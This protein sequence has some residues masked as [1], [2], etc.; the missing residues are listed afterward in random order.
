MAAIDP[1][2]RMHS[3]KPAPGT[4]QNEILHSLVSIASSAANTQIDQFGLRLADALMQFSD[5]S[6]DSKQA[7]LSFNAANLLKKNVYAFHF[8][9]ST[10]LQKT[11]LH[12]IDVNEFPQRSARAKTDEV[13]SLVPY[14]DMEKKLLLSNMARPLDA[15][16]ADQLTALRIRIAHLLGREEFSNNQNPFRPEVLLSA[17]TDAWCEFNPDIET[18]SLVLPLL[19]PDVFL[20]LT[21]VL[22]ALNN[23]LIACGIMPELADFYNIKKTTGNLSS[24]KTSDRLDPATLQQLRQIFSP[25]HEIAAIPAIPAGGIPMIAGAPMIPGL[26]SMPQSADTVSSAYQNQALQAAVSSNPLLGFLAGLQKNQL[27]HQAAAGQ[28]SVAPGVSMLASIKTEAPLGTLTRIDESTIDLLTKIFDVVFRDQNIPTEIK[29]L[30]GFLQVPVL[31]AALIDKDFFFKEEHPARRLIELL[32]KTSVGWDQSRGQDDPLYQTIKRN[33]SRVQQEFDEQATVFSDVVCDLESFIQQEESTS[34]EALSEP[35]A[36][37]LIQE[38]LGQANKAAKHEVALRIGTGEVVAFVETF[39][40]N[41]WVSVLALAYSIKD[42]KPRAVESALKT[43]DD[44]V[45]SVKPKIKKEERKELIAKLP[46]MLSMLNKWLNLVKLDDADR[47]QFFAELAECHASIVRAPL[48]MSPLRRL[49]IAMDVAKQAAERRLQRRAVEEAD[50][51]AD[52][53]TC[54]V[55]KLERGM[56]L[57]FI[58]ENA[59]ARKVKLSWVSPLRS[60]YIFSS[61]DKT[62][63]FSLSAEDL[64]QALREGRAQVILLDGLVDRAIT[65]ALGNGGANDAN[66]H[67]KSAA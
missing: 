15:T 1:P 60:L 61:R 18:H 20:D 36:E 63:S 6:G 51:V 2:D 32:T 50:Q 5:T 25:Q 14:A 47:L 3:A 38:K 22:L 24:G 12:E 7:S 45:W 19:R 65:E 48:E 46:S 59:A 54:H 42:E 4:A 27:V 66:M 29:G 37:A 31:K 35:I 34:A 52:D 67:E 10:H 17:I 56:W 8:V 30:I 39:L 11:I 57:E 13:L 58:Q 44:L 49:E 62:E 26:G 28:N 53:F 9:A 64:A 43:M 23:K 40:E 16:H 55:E 21:P 41:K 33:V